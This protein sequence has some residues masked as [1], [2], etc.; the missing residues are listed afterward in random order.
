MGRPEPLDRSI[1][2]TPAPAVADSL[3]RP[4]SYNPDL[5]GR[6]Q[7]L[8]RAQIPD[9]PPPT[10]PPGLAPAPVPPP[11]VPPVPTTPAEQFNCGVVHD[12]PPA[13]GFFGKCGNWLGGCKNWLGGVCCPQ[14]CA[15]HCLFQSDH[16][17]DGMISPVSN[18]F[19]F[20]DPRSLTEARFIGMVQ[21]APRDNF[22]FHGGDI[23][24]AGVQAR[25]ALTER[26]S[27]VVSELG[28]VWAEPH[29]G[30]IFGIN[31]GGG[32]AEV[33]VGPKYTF[34]RCENTGTV[35][36]VGVNFDI[37]A[38]SHKVFQDTGDLSIEPYVTAAQTFG[39]TSYGSFN[40]M[41]TLGYS[42]GSDDRR[43]DFL[44]NSV[45]L[46]FNIANL[47]MFYPFV[48]FNY[49]Y[50]TKAGNGP[51]LGFEG[52]DLFNFGAQGVSG[53][54][55]F[56][57]APG[58]RYKYREWLQTGVAVELPISGHR[59]LIDYRVTFDVILRF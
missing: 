9:P 39:R 29:N 16:C 25:L 10:P 55:T 51:Q 58:F 21:G 43:T 40:V 12:P 31:P 3:I 2:Y 18:P 22:V 34:Y 54:N 59:D 32:F 53:N 6:P 14:S 11:G 50:Y 8:V 33:R 24:Y 19:L 41:D 49:F 44:F 7:P 30:G 36:A 13:E 1:L 4:V 20:E 23:E 28:A 35:A 48:E 47:N 38:G 5:L 56:T 26:L 37:A 52:R 42:V 45:H 46:D 57:V 17:F 15:G 27:L